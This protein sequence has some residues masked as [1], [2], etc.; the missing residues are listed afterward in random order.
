MSITELTQKVLISKS[1]DEVLN[2]LKDFSN[3]EFSRGYEMGFSD[4]KVDGYCEGYDV[5]YGDGV[6]DSY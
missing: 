5:G 2:M 4:G 1:A 3:Q 6:C